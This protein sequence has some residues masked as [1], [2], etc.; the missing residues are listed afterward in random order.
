MSAYWTRLLKETSWG[1][2][3]QEY[4]AIAPHKRPY[5]HELS[6]GKNFAIS[7]NSATGRT[8][9]Y[10]PFSKG[11]FFK[12]T[13]LSSQIPRTMKFV[14]SLPGPLFAVRYLISNPSSGL[15]FHRDPNI[16]PGFGLVRF[17]VPL[18]TESGANFLV[19]NEVFHLPQG[20][21]YFVDVG[22]LHAIENRT[23]RPRVHLV[24]DIGWTHELEKL[25]PRNF[26]SQ[27][28]KR[29]SPSYFRR[30]L[31]ISR[32]NESQAPFG[33]YLIPRSVLPE[34][35]KFQQ[36]D[37]FC[38][39]WHGQ[40]LL[41]CGQN[42]L[43]FEVSLWDEKWLFCPSLGPGFRFRK[44]SGSLEIV[45]QGQFREFKNGKT[46]FFKAKAIAHKI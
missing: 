43:R 1:V 2:L 29:N 15:S 36:L 5:R 21:L 46:R 19:E 31:K 7:L 27:L 37:N 8:S 41:L 32:P 10:Y 12:P 4:L 11:H 9:N 40:K 28:K 16:N 14:Q 45:L 18:V 22:L 44:K 13:T 34:S 17:H 20:G 23:S 26:L 25:F 39:K 6:L 3:R 42:S 38:F 24:I 35:L 30:D 33:N